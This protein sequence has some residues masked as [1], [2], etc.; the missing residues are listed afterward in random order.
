MNSNIAAKYQE[1]ESTSVEM[2]QHCSR[3][4]QATM[5]FYAETLNTGFEEIADGVLVPYLLYYPAHTQ[6]DISGFFKHI[7]Y[8]F[9]PSNVAEYPSQEV[10]QMNDG[11]IYINRIIDWSRDNKLPDQMDPLQLVAVKKVADY[12]EDKVSVENMIGRVHRIVLDA[13]IKCG[14]FDDCSWLE[15]G[16]FPL[17]MN[18]THVIKKLMIEVAE[19]LEALL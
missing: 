13:Q 14:E 11:G 17:S 2:R 7:K 3:M 1:I 18:R 10:L 16:K 12:V 6:E 4:G 19:Q 9:Y 5:R 8:V 15:T